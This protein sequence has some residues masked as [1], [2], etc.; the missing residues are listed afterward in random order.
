[1]RGKALT[2]CRMQASRSCKS[3]PAL[4]W[5]DARMWGTIPCNTRRPA[6]PITLPFFGIEFRPSHLFVSIILVGLAPAIWV[7]ANLETWIGPA[8]SISQFG[9]APTGG[10]ADRETTEMPPTE[11]MQWHP[12]YAPDYVLPS[13]G[14]TPGRTAPSPGQTSLPKGTPAPA[15]STPAPVAPVPSGTHNR[16]T[17]GSST[18]TPPTTPPTDPPTTGPTTIPSTEAPPPPPPTLAPATPQTHSAPISRPP[19]ADR[20]QK[21]PVAPTAPAS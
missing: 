3:P 13:I 7:G 14:S 8:P 20:A 21:T 17:P 12:P 5:A 16:P 15:P 9:D 10:N 2:G 4:T 1:M 11:P 6:M 18:G 19:V